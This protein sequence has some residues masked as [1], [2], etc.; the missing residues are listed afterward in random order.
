MRLLD[1]R[2]RSLGRLFDGLQPA[3]IRVSSMISP[4]VTE[5]SQARSEHQKRDAIGT[6][7]EVAS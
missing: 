3:S 1:R 4:A 7:P 6:A 2:R 5:I